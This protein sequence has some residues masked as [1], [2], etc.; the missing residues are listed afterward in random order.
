MLAK[1]PTEYL[2]VALLIA[3]TLYGIF[4]RR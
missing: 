2:V 4:R 3:G 1:T